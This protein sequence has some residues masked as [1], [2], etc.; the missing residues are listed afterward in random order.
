MSTLSPGVVVLI[1]ILV[2][3]AVV[4]VAAAMHRVYS[5]R[6]DREKNTDAEGNDAM[7]QAFSNEQAH[8]MRD[9]RLRGQLQA[10]GVAPAF[11]DDYQ[12]P[13]SQVGR[14]GPGTE[15]SFGYG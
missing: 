10:W 2:A 1:A 9:V 15:T 5:G 3:A 11:E 6:G 12:P 13:R 7:I 4:A 8:Y 14:G